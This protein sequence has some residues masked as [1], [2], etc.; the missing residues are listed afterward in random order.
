MRDLAPAIAFQTPV[1]IGEVLDD[2][3]VTN[4]MESWLFGIFAGIAVLLAVIGIYGLLMQEVTSRIRDIGVRMALGATR[5]KIVQAVLARISLLTG[6]GLGSGVL[7]TIL[8]RRVVSSVLLIQFKGEGVVIA[9]L[10]MM[11]A[12]V[13]LLAALFPARRAAKV[14]P[15]VALRY[16]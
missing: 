12:F 5:S 10:V 13:G 9:A 6:I 3:L 2:T 16:E 15:M 7:L 8:L 14:D 11:M 1:T 4:R